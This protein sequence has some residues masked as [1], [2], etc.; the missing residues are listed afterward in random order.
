MDN[1][2]KPV[3]LPRK[4]ITQQGVKKQNESKSS[5]SSGALLSSAT[6]SQSSFKTYSEE[7]N[8]SEET[9]QEKVK[10]FGNRKNTLSKSFFSRP[11]RT[12]TYTTHK[13]DEHKIER[14]HS[15]PANNFFESISFKSPLV[16]DDGEKETLNI[17]MPE[18]DECQTFNA[19]PPIYPPPPLPDE[20]VYDEVQSVKSQ[21][22]VVDELNYANSDSI[23]CCDTASIY[24]DVSIISSRANDEIE[25]ISLNVENVDSGSSFQF[26]MFRPSD[27]SA[28]SSSKSQKSLTPCNYDSLS[29]SSSVRDSYINE[30]ATSRSS[31]SP[32]V[33][34][35]LEMSEYNSS[36][37][38]AYEEDR[39]SSPVTSSICTQNDLYDNWEPKHEYKVPDIPLRQKGEPSKKVNSVIIEF[40]PLFDKKFLNRESNESN[41]LVTNDLYDLSVAESPYGKIKRSTNTVGTI[42]EEVC[43]PIPPRRV[44]SI[45]PKLAVSDLETEISEQVINEETVQQPQYSRN[46]DKLNIRNHT[47]LSSERPTSSQTKDESSKPRK[48]LSRWPSVKH[49]IKLVSDSSWSPVM[50]RNGKQSGKN[51]KEEEAVFFEV[52]GIE[53][54]PPFNCRQAT[55]LYSANLFKITGNS[56][57]RQKDVVE[58]WCNL[59]EAK[60][61]I[62]GDKSMATVKDVVHLS[63]VTSVHAVMDYKLK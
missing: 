3:P 17:D 28:E 14:S 43:P 12:T 19:P 25:N 32:S 52:S 11:R 50:R 38:D 9:A 1:N 22:S 37:E 58:Q 30:R 10:S 42:T 18:D 33:L 20:S 56:R 7:P 24:E 49:A 2:K 54:E 47:K 48:P 27:A 40:D 60:F 31:I 61:V 53:I 29:L 21:S 39:F 15:L 44:D 35:E 34:S 5:R 46:S 51:I 36:P 8:L 23:S 26:D 41:V 59:S 16:A 63:T 57:E 6:K 4:L 62:Y 55:K 45:A 13:N